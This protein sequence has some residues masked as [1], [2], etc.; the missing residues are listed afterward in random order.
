MARSTSRRGGA[1]VPR[2]TTGGQL[3]AP[4][5]SELIGPNAIAV[6]GSAT[7]AGPIAL[8]ADRA[9]EPRC[10]RV[11]RPGA[12][13]QREQC[14]GRRDRSVST[15]HATMVSRSGTGAVQ[16]G[17]ATDESPRSVAEAGGVR[18]PRPL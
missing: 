16:P 12:L 4:G 13:H 2:S 3:N 14:D 11:E 7:G 18:G 17:L 9:R 5:M 15:L 10:V 8:L 1:C 6:P